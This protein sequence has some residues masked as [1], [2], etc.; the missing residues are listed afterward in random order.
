MGN[1][2]GKTPPDLS[3][4]R[5]NLNQLKKYMDHSTW[6]G[7]KPEDCTAPNGY[8]FVV[9]RHDDSGFR[10]MCYCRGRINLYLNEKGLV[11]HWNEG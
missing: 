3:Q 1:K 2:Q 5:S 8:Y 7:A 4:F 9:I 6:I 10:K 11:D